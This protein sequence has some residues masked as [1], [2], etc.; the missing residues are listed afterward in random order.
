[1]TLTESLPRLRR[2]GGPV[3]HLTEEEEETEGTAVSQVHGACG[4]ASWDPRPTLSCPAGPVS[5]PREALQACPVPFS[6]GQGLPCPSAKHGCP[7]TQCC[8]C[9]QT[10]SDP[11]LRHTRVL[12]TYPVPGAVLTPGAHCVPG[13]PTPGRG[14]QGAYPRQMEPLDQGRGSTRP[15]QGFKQ[16][17]FSA[18]QRLPRQGLSEAGS[19]GCQLRA[20]RA[21]SLP[22][23]Q[24]WPV[25]P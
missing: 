5:P 22:Q 24:I 4:G 7:L 11:Q 8:T 25:I 3:A 1:M 15:C 21:A 2:L 9:E 6:K 20:E 14:P 18:F 19:W 12:N 17:D 16:P 23:T 10:L 13:A